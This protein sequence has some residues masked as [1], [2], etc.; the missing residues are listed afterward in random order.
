MRLI[1]LYV[2]ISCLW[3]QF[4]HW[5]RLFLYCCKKK[6]HT[7][8]WVHN[9]YR[10]LLHWLQKGINPTRKFSKSS[11]LN[12]FKLNYDFCGRIGHTKGKCNKPYGY[13]L[14]YKL[15]KGPNQSSSSQAF[16]NQAFVV[17]STPQIFPFMAELCQQ[18]LVLINAQP[19]SNLICNPSS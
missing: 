8:L 7:G 3:I 1:R 11:P 2:A 19:R 14:G 10:I 17:S 13:P 16:A 15:Y 4:Q 18:I 6:D 5:V 12:N 9:L